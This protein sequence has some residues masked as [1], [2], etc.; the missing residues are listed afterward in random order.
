MRQ[1]EM[2][3]HAALISAAVIAKDHKHLKPK[4]SLTA[5]QSGYTQKLEDRVTNT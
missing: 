2:V 1:F 5:F 4:P 3:G